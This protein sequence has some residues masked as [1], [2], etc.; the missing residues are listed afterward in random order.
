MTI[1]Y[2]DQQNDLVVKG[3]IKFKSITTCIPTLHPNSTPHSILTE[4]AQSLHKLVY[5]D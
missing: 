5:G 1:C 2:L 3:Q 4:D